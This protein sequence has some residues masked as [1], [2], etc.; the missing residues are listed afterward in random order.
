MVKSAAGKKEAG[1][2]GG[3]RSR[4]V[5]L[6]RRYEF[7]QHSDCHTELLM[8]AIIQERSNKKTWTS[9]KYRSQ[10]PISG[11]C[12]CTVRLIDSIRQCSP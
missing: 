2:G 11:L 9:V 3:I 12:N 7:F 6:E 10:T 4:P 5:K 8:V 1:F